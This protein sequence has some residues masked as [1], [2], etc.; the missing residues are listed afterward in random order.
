MEDTA[1]VIESE[2]VKYKKDLQDQEKSSILVFFVEN[3]G[4]G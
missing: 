1:L 2:K 4:A 3:L